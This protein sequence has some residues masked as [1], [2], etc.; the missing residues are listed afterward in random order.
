MRLSD[1]KARFARSVCGKRGANPDERWAA[2]DRR[3]RRQG[4]NARRKS[5]LLVNL[6]MEY[7]S[8]RASLGRTGTSGT[9]DQLLPV[10]VRMY[11]VAGGPHVTVSQAP[12]CT[13]PAGRL[14]WAPYR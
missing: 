14:D 10:N 12:T 5:C 13:R 8:L 1:F 4:R 6:S 3:N 7:Y 2:H 11:D 9:A